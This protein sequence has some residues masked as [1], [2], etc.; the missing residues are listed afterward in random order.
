MMNLLT[1]PASSW[2]WCGQPA[3]GVD[4]VRVCGWDYTLHAVERW[5]IH[6]PIDFFTAAVVLLA[7]SMLARAGFLPRQRGYG[8]M[9]TVWVVGVFAS[10]VREPADVADGDSP[11]K[12]WLDLT[13][14]A[15]DQAVALWVFCQIAPRLVEALDAMKEQRRNM[16][17]RRERRARRRGSWR[18]PQ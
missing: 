10:F 17:R 13:G 5:L 12:S 8:F 11:W 9:F 4:G 14:H 16:R 6:V 18:G 7:A 2:S 15:I 3:D 1:D